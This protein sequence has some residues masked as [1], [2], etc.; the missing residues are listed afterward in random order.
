VEPGKSRI[1]GELEGEAGYIR[2]AGGNTCSVCAYAGVYPIL[3]TSP[4]LSSLFFN[5]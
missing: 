2:L 4:F 1:L 3:F 5:I